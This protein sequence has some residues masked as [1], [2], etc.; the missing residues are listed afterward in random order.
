MAGL[1]AGSSG[2]ADPE[3]LAAV[4]VADVES[5]RQLEAVLAEPRWPGFDEIGRDGAHALWL[6]AQHADSRPDLQREAL[7]K[8]E[9]RVKEGQADAGD[10]AYLTDRVRVACGEPQKFGTQFTAD[11]EGVQ[12]PFP[13]EAPSEL[14]RRRAELGLP[15]MADYA[16]LLSRALGVPARPEPLAAFPPRPDRAGARL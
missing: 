12:R 11:A 10:F 15:S 13:V 4:R 16:R 1:R 7:R 6:L 9:L 2:Q 14:E 3:L 5:L 8:M